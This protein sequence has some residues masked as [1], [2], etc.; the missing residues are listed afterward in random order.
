MHKVVNQGTRLEYAFP[1]LHGNTFFINGVT[2]MVSRE[3]YKLFFAIQKLGKGKKLYAILFLTAAIAD[4]AKS[5]AMTKKAEDNSGT[6]F[7]ET[8]LILCSLS[9][10][11]KYM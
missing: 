7:S 9:P 6:M 1:S 8:T 4:R 5:T 3:P 10:N 2:I 11:S